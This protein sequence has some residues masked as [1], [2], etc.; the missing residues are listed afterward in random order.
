MSP[1]Q[2]ESPITFGLLL[3]WTPWAIA[4]GGLLYTITDHVITTRTDIAA[5]KGRMSAAE[6][7][8]KSDRALW[9]RVDRRTLVLVCRTDPTQCSAAQ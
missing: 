6:A 3:K 7:D 4:I 1:R 5:L 2:A 8:R 9:E